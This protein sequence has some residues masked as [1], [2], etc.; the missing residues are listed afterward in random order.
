MTKV[1]NGMQLF[2]VNNVPDGT[3][4]HRSQYTINKS[5]TTKEPKWT[6]WEPVVVITVMVRNKPRRKVAA[7]FW[8]SYLDTLVKQQVVAEFYQIPLPPGH[9]D[10]AEGKTQEPQGPSLRTVSDVAEPA[11]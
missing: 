11:G 4:W 1:H 6:F 3:F 7:R 9:P 8:N 2:D 10:E 5:D